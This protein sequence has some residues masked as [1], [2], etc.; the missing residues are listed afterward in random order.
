MKF[1][2]AFKEMQEAGACI[3]RSGWNGKGMYIWIMPAATVPLE[4]CK[5][6]R[7]KRLAEENGGSVECLATI[8]MKTVDGKVMTGWVPT[9]GDMAADDWIVYYHK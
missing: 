5:E 6:P 4:W 7:L 1:I 9:Q 2:E 3:A 8:R